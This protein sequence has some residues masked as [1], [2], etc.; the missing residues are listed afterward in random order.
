MQIH[1][2]DLQPSTTA[3]GQWDMCNPQC[4][5]VGS[6]PD[7]AL[8]AGSGGATV[9]FNIDPAKTTVTF[10]ATVEDAIWIKPGNKPNSAIISPAGQVGTPL[11]INGNHTLIVND[12]NSG[13]GM[14]LH[15]RLNFSDGTKIDPVIKNGGGGGRA[16][17]V[18]TY[19]LV[20][21]VV[22]ALVSI[23]FVR[24]VMNWRRAR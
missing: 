8:D 7:I 2:I 10:P 17:D 23:L 12:K 14:D 20:G 1:V 11:L 3:P 18:A 6:Y 13:K 21:A 4:V 24:I 22:G 16:M 9:V 5:G 19:A 15:Y